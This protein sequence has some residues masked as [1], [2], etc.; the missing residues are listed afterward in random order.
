MEQESPRIEMPNDA[1]ELKRESNPD[2]LLIAYKKT[3]YTITTKHPNL[4]PKIQMKFKLL[5][6]C[7]LSVSSS[8]LAEDY[9]PE[10]FQSLKLVYEDNFSDGTLNTNYWQV[11]QGTTWGVKD[12]ALAGSPSPKEFQE[13]MIAKGD[14][15]HAGFKPVIWLEKVPENLVAHFRVRF[16][17]ENFQPK[18]PLIDV[19]H[20]VNTLVF[21]ENKT[22]LILKKDQKTIETEEA[23]LPLNKWVDVT[24]ELKKGVLLLKVD[25]RKVIFKDL[26]IDMVDQQQ[27]DFK[28][29]DHGGISI[30]NVKVYE[31]IN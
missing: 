17:A 23:F 30:D 25:E 20:H 4:T 21:S 8:L 9:K 29:V 24:I 26:L 14:K 31:G 18:F 1:N 11:R 19:G 7:F 6:I 10:L 15:A 27:I 28:G 2:S 13:Q 3:F 5:G 12:G 16:N 22:T